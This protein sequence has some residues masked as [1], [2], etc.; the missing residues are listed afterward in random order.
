MEIVYVYQ[1]IRSEF[2]RHCAFKDRP[3]KVE[4]DI[5]PNDEVSCSPPWM[6]WGCGLALGC[7]GSSAAA[8]FFFHCAG[9]WLTHACPPCDR[10]AQGCVHGEEPVDPRHE[11]RPVPVGARGITPREPQRAHGAH[12]AQW[13]ALSRFGSTCPERHTAFDTRPPVPRRTRMWSSSR[14]R[15]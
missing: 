2:G 10:A 7:S 3:A 13:R 11:L 12:S 6:P 15:A 4:I 14:T 8:A 5:V 1:K 9:G